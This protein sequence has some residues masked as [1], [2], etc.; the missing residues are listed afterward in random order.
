MSLDEDK[1]KEAIKEGAKQ[2]IREWMDSAFAQFGRWTFY[3]LVAAVLGG[4]VTFLIWL[5]GIK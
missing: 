1:L 3:G 5:K 2:A 4:F